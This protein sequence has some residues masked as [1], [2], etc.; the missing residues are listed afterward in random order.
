LDFE[1][2][3]GLSAPE[4]LVVSYYKIPAEVSINYCA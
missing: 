4:T 3:F 1:A 2:R